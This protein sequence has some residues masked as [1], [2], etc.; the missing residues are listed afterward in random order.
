MNALCAL[1]ILGYT[2]HVYALNSSTCCTTALMKLPDTR[3]VAP[4]LLSTPY[5]LPQIFLAFTRFPATI[6]QSS[7]PSVKILPIYLNQGIV[8]N[9]S[10]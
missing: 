8:C 9:C 3:L 1:S 5:S 10:P 7:S 6:S 2:T 4:S